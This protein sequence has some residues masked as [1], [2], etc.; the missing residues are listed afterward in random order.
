M[1]Y[2]TVIVTQSGNIDKVLEQMI[3]YSIA[4]IC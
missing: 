1:I 3:S 4:I 2:V